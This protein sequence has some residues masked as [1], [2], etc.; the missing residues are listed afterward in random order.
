[1][2]KFKYITLV[3]LGYEN[4][5]N[6]WSIGFD[7]FIEI[8]VLLNVVAVIVESYEN[9]YLKYQIKL[10]AFEIFTVIV[11][12]LEFALR[13][14]VADI[15]FPSKSKW[16][17]RKQYLVSPP[18]I[19]DFLAILPF[20]IPFILKVDLRHLRI[21][22]LIR[23]MRVF[24]LSKYSHSIAVIGKILTEKRHEMVAT[25]L[26]LFSILIF[27]SSIMY[28]TEKDVQPEAFP[29]ILYAFWWGIITLTTIGYGDVYPITGLGKVIGGFVAILGILI[30]AIPTGIISSS[31]VQ[32]MEENK[33][34]K[35]M[36]EIKSKVKEAFYKKYI[37]E[38]GCQVRRGQLSI[39]AVKIHLELSENEVYKIAEGKNE[40]R[41]RNKKIFQNG[42]LTDK[43]YLEFREINRNY[44]TFNNRNH[45]LTLVSP[46]SFIKE[47]IGYFVYCVSEKLQCNYVSNE[48]FGVESIPTEQSFGDT[49]LDPH[50]AFSFI[51]NESYYELSQQNPFDFCEWKSDLAEIRQ[52][53][54]IYIIFDTFQPEECKNSFIHLSYF[55][56]ENIGQEKHHPLNAIR[57]NKIK[58]SLLEKSEHKFAQK[59]QISENGDFKSIA[60]NNILLFIKDTI[61]ADTL[62]VSVCEDYIAN[63]KLF[64][65]A[66]IISETIQEDLIGKS[67]V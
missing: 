38:L 31:F 5:G 61:Q 16:T 8:L 44:G 46:E 34:L 12:S 63:E 58:K 33:Y 41:F 14:W 45:K 49:A 39:D 55:Q 21:F 48:F 9:I 65:M 1:M 29:N 42:L 26:L 66:K 67:I 60:N 53:N 15:A 20:F 56:R 36:I 51:H 52:S 28:Y 23:L 6:K 19:I 13:I 43:V 30:V 57:M 18:A 62:L 64:V 22:R 47:G 50:T 54:S 24:K 25:L 7:L 10:D 2:K 3:I 17:S 4:K 27:A 35:R 37:P 11:F 40:F 59:L 32:K